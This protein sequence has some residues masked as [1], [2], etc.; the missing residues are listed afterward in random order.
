MNTREELI[1]TALKGFLEQ[2]YDN[3]SIRDL[4]AKLDIKP[5][6]IYYYFPNKQML[7]TECVTFFYESWSTW[8]EELLTSEMSLQEILSAIC[9]NLGSDKILLQT[10]F[11]SQ[12][13]TGQ[14]Y[15]VLD[16]ARLFPESL[17]LM[18]S[19]NEK[20]L[21]LITIKTQEAHQKGLIKPDITAESIYYLL[22][23]VLEGSN[24]LRITDP[25]MEPDDHASAIFQMLWNG[26]AVITS[27]KEEPE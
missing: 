3:L 8:L 24:I 5:A 18:Q 17:Q 2:G 15:L 1:H 13:N 27:Q 16:A 9:Q 21:Q 26:I 23:S 7:F 14:Y 6:S 12:T 20:M 19:N 10:L 4:A 11:Q 22:S 25:E